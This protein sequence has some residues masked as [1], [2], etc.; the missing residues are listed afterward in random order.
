MANFVPE[1]DK[2]PAL[3]VPF[4]EDQKD[5]KIPGRGTE[6]SP[7]ELQAEVRE[8]M[9]KL[10]AYSVMFKPG[11]FQD[12]PIRYGYQITFVLAGTPGRMD[13]AALPMKSEAAGKK[14]RALAQSLYLVRNWLE[15]EVFSQIY[16]PGNV[17]LLPYLVGDG[18]LTINE[19]M[20]RSGTIP[21]LT[22]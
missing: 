12:N 2:M 19:A 10:G 9:T 16:R 6:K 20:V 8:L 22:G 13:I 1:E 15:A 4:F 17:P 14:D 21:L 11:K 7:A 3:M 5:A 18:D